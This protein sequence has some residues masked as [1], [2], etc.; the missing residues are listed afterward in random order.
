MKQISLVLVLAPARAASLPRKR[1]KPFCLG[2]LIRVFQGLS[3]RAFKTAQRS[4]CC[5]IAIGESPR[6][7]QDIKES[8]HPLASSDNFINGLIGGALSLKR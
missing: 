4:C 3:S 2:S 8:D 5:T 6:L 7:N 1:E